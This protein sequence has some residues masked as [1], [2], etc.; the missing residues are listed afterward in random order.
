MRI[1][2][3]EGIGY[4]F[5]NPDNQKNL[6]NICKTNQLHAIEAEGILL[7][8]CSV[9]K[10]RRPYQVWRAGEHDRGGS[11]ALRRAA[12]AARSS[13]RLQAAY[14]AMWRSREGALRLFSPCFPI[15]ALPKI[16]GD[17]LLVEIR[18]ELDRL[19]S[20]RYR[21]NKVYRPTANGCKI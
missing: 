19:S 5:L 13:D 8:R 17:G 4:H 6:A 9:T 11:R 14:F 15:K 16:N 3:S 20:D 12:V 7:P 10:G 1:S 2:Q 18:C 21:M